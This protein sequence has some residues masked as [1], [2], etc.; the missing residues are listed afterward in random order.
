[1]TVKAGQK[2]TA[3]RRAMAPAE[4]LDAVEEALRERLGEDEGRRPARRGHAHGRAGQHRP[5]RRRPRA[6]RRARGRGAASSPATPT[7]SRRSKGGA[8]LS[9][10]LLR[11]DDPWATAA[12]STTSSRSARSR[13]SCPI[14]TSTTRSRSPTAAWAACACRCSPI[15]P[16]GARLRARRRRLSRPH[17]GHRPRQCR[18][19]RPATARLAGPR[20]WR[21]RPR[22]RRRG[23]GRHPRRHALHAAHRHPVVAGDDRR[24][25]PA[26]LLPGAPKH[27]IDVHPFRRA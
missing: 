14:A 3:I 9:P 25:Q 1:M 5:A 19:I 2:C 22:R 4:H 10:V 11:T 13:P 21:P 15:R 16:S 7:P 20:P 26:Q 12:P 8:F 23:D 18:R 6:D 17:A 27:A 24:D